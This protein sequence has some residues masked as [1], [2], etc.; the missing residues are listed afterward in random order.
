MQIEIPF[1]EQFRDPMLRGRKNFTTRNKRYGKAG[2]TFPAFGAGFV[3]QKVTKIPL[4]YVA[5]FLY[6]GEGFDT[7]EA[8]IRCWQKLHPR[9][10]YVPGQ[11]VYVHFFTKD[12][13]NSE[14][15][16]K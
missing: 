11:S 14:L 12:G 16:A 4:G 10:G 2:D 6:R 8:F 3:L 13:P 1:S 15:A 5:R 7:P 9:K